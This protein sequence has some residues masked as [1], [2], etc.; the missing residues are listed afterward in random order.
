L[1]AAHT[2]LGAI[3]VY[4][5][6]DRVGTAS[7][8]TVTSALLLL[9]ESDGNPLI[10]GTPTDQVSPTRL[11]STENLDKSLAAG[12]AWSAG[13]KWSSQLISWA[14]FVIVTRLLVPSDFGLVGMAVLYCGLLQVATDAFGTAVT[15]LRDLTG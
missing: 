6:Y 15:T 5:S 14:S 8:N 11:T 3:R 4:V 13:A 10:P 7:L 12:I 1:F 2:N 9:C